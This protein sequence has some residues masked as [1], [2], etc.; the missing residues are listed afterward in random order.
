MQP[1]H[2]H[3]HDVRSTAR[4][5]DLF[6][7]APKNNADQILPQWQALPEQTRQTLTSLLARLMLDHASADHPP[8]LEEAKP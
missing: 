7:L 8:L 2:S 4:Q 1:R 5:F 6:E 3:H